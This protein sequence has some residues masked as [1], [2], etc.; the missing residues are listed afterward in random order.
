MRGAQWLASTLAASGATGGGNGT[1]TAQDLVSTGHIGAG[2][3]GTPPRPAAQATAGFGSPL[4]SLAPLA[5]THPIAEGGVAD[6]P[7]TDADAPPRP[8]AHADAGEVAASSGGAATEQAP[9]GGKAASLLAADEA[10]SSAAVPPA[11]PPCPPSE[12]APSSSSDVS[13]ASSS[14]PF[15]PGAACGWAAPISDAGPAAL[16]RPHRAVRGH[17]RVRSD[18]LEVI[19]R[20]SQRE[21][22]KGKRVAAV[23]RRLAAALDDDP[24][25]GG[26]SKAGVQVQPWTPSEDARILRGV[27]E[28]GCKWSLIAQVRGR[29]A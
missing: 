14:E 10:A 28:A 7:A 18:E 3:V 2:V 25:L 26:S 24:L 12:A 29:H 6:A 13:F 5:E 27:K 8:D 20:Y 11:P 22:G 4:P 16:G 23:P 15:M 21:P 1:P 19:R 9:F 17:S